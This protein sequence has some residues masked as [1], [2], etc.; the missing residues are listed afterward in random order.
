MPGFYMA[1]RSKSE[2]IMSIAAEV[3]DYFESLIKP[4]VTNKSQ[5]KLLEVFQGKILE[6]FEEKLDEQN[7]KIKKLQSKTAIQVNA[8]QK[9]EIKCDE[10]E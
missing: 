2:L 1:T 7:A 10:N 6:R 4:L 5:E 9:L 8:L 3:L